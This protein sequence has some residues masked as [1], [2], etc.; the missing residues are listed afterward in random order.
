MAELIYRTLRENI[1]DIIRKRIIYQELE[2]GQKIV[3]QDLAKEFKTSRAPIREALRQLENEGLIEYVRNAGCSVKEI[4]LAVKLMGGNVPEDTICRMEEVLEKMKKLDEEQFDQV[5]VYDNQMHGLLVEMTGMTRLYKA[6]K[7]LNYG[8]IVTGFSLS[9]D[10]KRVLERQYPIH[11]E[12]V[13][14][15]REKNKEKICHVLSDHYMRTIRRLLKE[16]GLS[17]ED[18]GFSCLGY[19]E[20]LQSLDS[21]KWININNEEMWIVIF[22]IFFCCVLLNYNKKRV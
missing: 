8:N 13:D 1:A 19:R 15:C 4:T 18:S 7:E 5:F 6:W 22:H 12:L 21:S 16:Q 3:E 17:E 10:K 20:R 11:K 14:A 2:P 9:T